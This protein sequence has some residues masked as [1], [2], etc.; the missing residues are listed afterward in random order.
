VCELAWFHNAGVEGLLSVI[1]SFGRMRIQQVFAL[2]R[3]THDAVCAVTIRDRCVGHESCLAKVPPVAIKPVPA[4][5]VSL[6]VGGVDHP[7]RTHGGEGPGLRFVER[8]GPVSEPH[9]LALV[10]TRQRQ[11]TGEDVLFG[12]GPFSRD[13]TLG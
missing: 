4:M 8:V 3:E 5:L 13:R 12:F 11:A 1:G 9:A 6:E 7:K 10:A 2:S